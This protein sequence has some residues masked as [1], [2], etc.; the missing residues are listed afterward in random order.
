MRR[1]VKSETRRAKEIR[2]PESEFRK[3]NPGKSKNRRAEKLGTFF[4][5]RNSEFGFPSAPRLRISFGVLCAHVHKLFGV[6][7]TTS[8][9]FFSKAGGISIPNCAAAAG[10][11]LYLIFVTNSN[12]MS[13]GFSPRRTRAAIRAEATPPS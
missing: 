12:G 6:H 9:A 10:L 3:A 7:S 13:A 1:V 5:I 2:I 8:P 4:G 11:K